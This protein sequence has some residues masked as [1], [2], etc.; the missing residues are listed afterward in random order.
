MMQSTATAVLPTARSPM[1]SSRCPR[2]SANIVSMTSSPVWIGSLTKSR[3][4]MAGAGRSIGSVRS[5]LMLPPPSIGRPNGST[6][7]PSSPAP[8]GTRTTSSV[9]RT[10]SP[11]STVSLSSRR[12]QPS[13]SRSS[14]SAKP[15]CPRSKRTSSSRRTLRSPETIAIPSATASTRPTSSA[16][17]ASDAV[18]TRSVASCSQ[19]SR[20]AGLLVTIQILTDAAKVRAP[21]VADD[22]VAP[23]QLYSC[24]QGRVAAKR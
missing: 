14:V 8:T 1:I 6:I 23:V 16:T 20:S 10:R 7:R 2:P 9:P 18:R 22:R 12:T 13:K 15:T 5:A 24:D 19:A 11:A 3:S 21:A 17:G 4:M